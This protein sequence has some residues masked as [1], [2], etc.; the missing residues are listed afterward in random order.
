ME[1]GWKKTPTSSY[2]HFTIPQA[3]YDDLIAFLS[4]YGKPVIAK[5]KHPRVMP[6]GILRLIVTVDEAQK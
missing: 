6:D 1:L 2:Y 4:I 5:E 3:K